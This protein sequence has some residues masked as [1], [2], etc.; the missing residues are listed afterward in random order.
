[1][2]WAAGGGFKPLRGYAGFHY[3]IGEIDRGQFDAVRRVDHAPTCCLLVR[4]EVF[5]RIGLMDKR[6]FVYID[7]ADFCFRAKRSRLRLFYLPP[8]QLFHKVSS[9]T[10]G[11]ESDFNARYC[12]RNR[13]YFM[14][15]NLG[16]GRA[17]YYLPAYQMLL[18]LRLASRR[19]DVSRFALREKAFIEGIRLWGHYYIDI[20]ATP[21]KAFADL[22]HRKGTPPVGVIKI[23]WLWGWRDKQQDCA[24][25][26]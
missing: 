10:G 22:R 5:S 23:R 16:L 13:I 9:L 4:Q 25:P 6:Y 3:G 1:M 19:I 18:F 20:E 26:Q 8:A 21:G 14:L 7:D 2:I 12:T 17:L 24:R 11:P 15:K